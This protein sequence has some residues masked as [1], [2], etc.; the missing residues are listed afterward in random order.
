MSSSNHREIIY[1][2]GSPRSGNTWLCRLLG[3]ALNSPI[4]SGLRFPSNA[5]EGFDR[6]GCFVI[7][8]RHHRLIHNGFPHGA[9]LIQIVRD[10]RDV[11]VSVKEYWKCQWS[12]ALV[13]VGRWQEHNREWLTRS[14]AVRF[15]D[16]LAEPLQYLDSLLI[17][18]GLEQSP[19]IVD[20]AVGRQ[21]WER[22]RKS[23]TPDLPYGPEHQLV[24]LGQGRTGRWR[25]NLTR[26]FGQ[27]AHI[28]FWPLMQ[29]LGYETDEHWWEEL[30]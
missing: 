14:P 9:R 28:L 4:Q 30:P 7:R 15:E 22:R 13:R 23:I 16:L 25:E 11:L 12:D 10:P 8:M 19:E 6:P 27:T 5:D 2:L 21:E 29:E 1:T 20:A 24:V 17:Q 26:E 3:D 18:I